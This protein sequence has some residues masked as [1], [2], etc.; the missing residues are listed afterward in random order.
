[1]NKHLPRINYDTVKHSKQRYDTAGDYFKVGGEP[2]S[3]DEYKVSRLPQGW[4]A[5][6]AVFVHEMVEFQ[7]CKEAGIKEKDI[8][9]FD[10]HEGKDSNDPGTMKSAPYHSQHILATSIE[11]YIIKKLGL[12]WREYDKSFETL[13]YPKK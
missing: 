7:L 5:E 10:T 1:M 11:R 2:C 9:Y 4:K 12:K 6:L 3:H 8:T 13:K